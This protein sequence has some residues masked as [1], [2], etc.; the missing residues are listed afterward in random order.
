MTNDPD[1]RFATSLVDY[2]FRRLALDHL[3]I[4][5]REAL[6]PVDRRTQGDRGG[7][8]GREA[9]HDG[10]GGRRRREG[11]GAAPVAGRGDFGRPTSAGRRRAALLHLRLEDAPGRLLLRLPLLRLDQRLLVS[12]GCSGPPVVGYARGRW[13]IGSPGST[14]SSSRCRSARR[15]PAASSTASCSAYRGAPNQR[16][17]AAGRPVVPLEWASR[18]TWASSA[19]NRPATKAHPAFLVTGLDELRERLEGDG[20]RIDEDVQLEGTAGSTCGIRSATASSSSNPRDRARLPAPGPGRDAARTGPPRGRRIRSPLDPGPRCRAGGAMVRTG[21]AVAIPSGTGLLEERSR[22]TRAHAGERS[23][24]HR[25]GVP[26]GADLLG[27]QPRPRRSVKIAR[28]DRIAQLVI[29]AVPEFGP[30]WVDE[31]PPS[32]RGEGGFGSTGTR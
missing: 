24:P 16:A 32:S 25:R 11:R 30:L 23:R 26:R 18:C 15:R 3:P 28:G 20:Y 19:R 2:V 14:T 5:Q 8:G 4:E 1:V 6:D 17:R 9:R 22:P 13:R 27:R 7:R 31:L 12:A 10:R 29:V 21:V